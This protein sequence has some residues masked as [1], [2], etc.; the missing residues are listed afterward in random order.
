MKQ[1]LKMFAS[2]AVC[3]FLVV[4]AWA[5]TLDGADVLT[6]LHV[7]YRSVKYPTASYFNSSYQLLPYE[8]AA[9]S[10]GKVYHYIMSSTRPYG[11]VETGQLNPYWG[12]SNARYQTSAI[13]VRGYKTASVQIFSSSFGF[14]SIPASVPLIIKYPPGSSGS[15]PCFTRSSLLNLL[16]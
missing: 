2:L 1:L 14:S 12:P 11:A 9:D 5:Q 4:P 8:S 10:T 7:A 15:S 6:N 13:D 3:L 16:R